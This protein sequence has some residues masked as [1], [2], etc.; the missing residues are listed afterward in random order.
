MLNQPLGLIK[1]CWPCPCPHAQAL[2]KAQFPLEEDASAL[3]WDLCHWPVA[4][5]EEVEEVRTRLTR[6]RSRYMTQLKADQTQMASDLEELKGDVEKFI[7]LGDVKQVC[8]A[9]RGLR[10]SSLTSLFARVS[11]SFFFKE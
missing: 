10:H 9:G 4:L 2:S 1:P 5:N 7:K 11:C 3:F 8:V 6:F